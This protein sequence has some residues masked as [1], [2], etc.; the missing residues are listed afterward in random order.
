M[1]KLVTRSLLILLS[2]I[3]LGVWAQAG[4]V[5]T[6]D[7]INGVITGAP[8]QIIGWGFTITN[9]TN[10]VVPTS[11]EFDPGNPL[12]GTY[13]DFIPFQF[14]VIGPAPESSTA[15]AAFDANTQSG[16]GSF[17]ILPGAPLGLLSGTLTLTYDVFSVS[18]NDPNFDPD[19]DLIAVNQILSVPAGVD[20]EVTPEPASFFMLGAG[21]LILLARK[22]LLGSR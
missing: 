1:K 21:G 11:S 18:P 16:L 20:V 22:R 19:A 17:A 4:T 7:P 5:F 12:V 2:G 13:M 8:G 6:A 9:D 15:T 10:F 14:F 3:L